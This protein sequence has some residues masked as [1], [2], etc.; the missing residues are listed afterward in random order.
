LGRGISLKKRMR[1]LTEVGWAWTNEVRWVGF[2]EDGHK[3]DNANWK[4]E[5]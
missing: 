3:V 1:T 5:G 4:G 2:M